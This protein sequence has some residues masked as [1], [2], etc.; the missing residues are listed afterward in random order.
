VTTREKG[1]RLGLKKKGKVAPGVG[2]CNWGNFEGG[3]LAPTSKGKR[4][5]EKKKTTQNGGEKGD[6]GKGYREDSRE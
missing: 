6:L 5:K 3:I 1:G 2:K 4:P